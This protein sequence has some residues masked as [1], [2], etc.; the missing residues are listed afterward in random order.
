MAGI[1]FLRTRMLKA[2][3]EF[4]TGLVG[5]RVWLEQPGVAILKHGN[6]LV[7][8]HEQPEADL[9][10][11][12]TFFYQRPEQVDEMHTTLKDSATSEPKDNPKYRIR[13]FYGRDPEGRR[14]EFQAFLHPVEHTDW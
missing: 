4:Y 11:L 13:H 12:L 14:I 10:G 1:V 5:M 2:V 9:G 7:G 3:R 8:F 6:M